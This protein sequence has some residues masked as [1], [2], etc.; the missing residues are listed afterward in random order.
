MLPRE[1]REACER[2]CDAQGYDSM[3]DFLLS[4]VAPALGRPELAPQPHPEHS[5]VEVR[6]I[7]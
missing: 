5:D 4:I 6:L 3:S 1:L 2:E 7:S